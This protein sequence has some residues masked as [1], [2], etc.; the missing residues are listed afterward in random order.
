MQIAYSEFPDG[1]PG[2]AGMPAREVASEAY[3]SA[4]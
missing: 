4:V 3:S 1:V 2:F